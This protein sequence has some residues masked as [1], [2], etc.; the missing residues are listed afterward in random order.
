MPCSPKGS[1]ECSTSFSER[2]S[3][4]QRS[5]KA[6]KALGERAKNVSKSFRAFFRH[7][8]E[9]KKGKIARSDLHVYVEN[10][11]GVDAN[12][13]ISREDVDELF[14]STPQTKDGLIEYC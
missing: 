13:P 12:D 4:S 8:D 1:T 3:D 5:V 11:R 14:D 6:A 9:E 10:T 7:L 2:S